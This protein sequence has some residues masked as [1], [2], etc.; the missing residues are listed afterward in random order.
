MV[1]LIH[2]LLWLFVTIETNKVIMWI[3]HISYNCYIT[4]LNNYC[5][6]NNYITYYFLV[7]NSS[8]ITSWLTGRAIANP[9]L[10]L[11]T[12]QTLWRLLIYIYCIWS[13]DS[14]YYNQIYILFANTNATLEKKYF[15]HAFQS[16]DLDLWMLFQSW[17]SSPFK[18]LAATSLTQNKVEMVAWPLPVINGQPLVLW[19][20]GC[21]VTFI[22]MTLP[23]PLP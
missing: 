19:K 8:V 5:V 12:T 4:C 17:I 14:I 15:P 6:I 11:T 22:A 2:S 7:Y 20:Q 16:R 23:Q 18:P 10:T 13:V 9:N 3:Y 1:Y 21:I